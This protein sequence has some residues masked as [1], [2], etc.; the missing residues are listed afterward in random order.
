MENKNQNRRGLILETTLKLISRGGVDAVSYRKVADLANI[1]LGSTTYYFDSREDLICET[2][3]FYIERAKRLQRKP[4]N[5]GTALA[6]TK[7]LVDV[8]NREFE[9]KSMLLAEYEMTLFAARNEKVAG[10]LH[11]WDDSMINNLAA[12][13]E[14]LGSRR[15]Y[16]AAQTILHIMRGY[17]LDKLSRSET[18]PESLRRRLRTVIGAFLP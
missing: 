3:D 8:T 12:V 6:F 2:F 4:R 14:S 18:D 5:I 11:A 7:Y 17:E 9:E 13:M 10:L 16:D 15:K 1:P